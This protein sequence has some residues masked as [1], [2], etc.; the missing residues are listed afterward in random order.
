MKLF[1]HIGL[2]KTG[3]TFLQKEVFTKIQDPEYF[4]KNNFVYNPSDIIDVLYAQLKGKPGDHSTTFEQ[5]RLKYE[6]RSVLISSEGIGMHP[7]KL[8]HAQNFE[9]ISNFIDDA[10]IILFLRYQPAW[11]ESVYKQSIHGRG[12]VVPIEKFLNFTDGKFG[13]STDSSYRNIDVNKLSYFD[14][15]QNYYQKF[16]KKNVHVLFY[17]NF[18]RDGA[19]FMGRLYSILELKCKKEISHTRRVNRGYSNTSIKITKVLNKFGITIKYKRKP[20]V[21]IYALTF[22]KAFK[23]LPPYKLIPIVTYKVYMWLNY[24]R[25]V[26][27]RW[28]MQNFIDKIYYS[29]VSLLDG[30]ESKLE[31]LFREENRKLRKIIPSLPK[32]YKS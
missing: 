22:K 4:E 7:F 30:Y 11:I 27:Y 18:L 26:Y 23:T 10:E 32:D 19:S 12:E 15:V 20:P 16:G 8:N 3:T 5:I 25:H 14:I 6:S 1:L 29:Q 2:H 9:I 31:N 24:N 28:V 13:A 17:E 21:G